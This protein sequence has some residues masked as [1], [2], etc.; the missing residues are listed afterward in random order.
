MKFI[1][2]ALVGTLVSYATAFVNPIEPWGETKWIPGSKVMIQWDDKNPEAPALSTNPIVDVFLMTGSDQS[3]VQLDVIA[4]D[5]NANTMR[6]VSYTVPT[7]DPIGKSKFL[8]LFV[9]LVC[10]LCTSA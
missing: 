4:K 3:M 9:I 6:N 1:T 2:L 7:V 8:P 5:I 10:C